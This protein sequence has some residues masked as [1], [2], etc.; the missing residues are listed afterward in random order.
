MNEQ[1]D[2][3]KLRRDVIPKKY[4]KKGGWR[5]PS[6]DELIAQNK[7]M[8]RENLTDELTRLPNIRAMNKMLVGLETAWERSKTKTD[9]D[10]ILEGTFLAV[11]LTALHQVNDLFGHSVGDT[12]LKTVAEVLSTDIRKN[13]RVFRNGEKSDEF[14][15]HMPSII[16]KDELEGVMNR[17]DKKISERANELQK[18]LPGINFSVSYAAV[19]YGINVGP[20]NAC[21][22]AHDEMGLA[23]GIKAQNTGQRG[24][25]IGRIII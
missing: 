13:D 25:N 1:I 18:N 19:R 3:E 6:V 20:S 14:T 16:D 12:Y 23:K 2:F 24:E 9:G 15:V 21:K 5:G 22:R 17:I 8:R 4:L 11:D 10:R 7:R